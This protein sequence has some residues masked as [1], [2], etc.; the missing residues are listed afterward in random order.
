MTSGKNN[1]Y[2]LTHNARYMPN[3]DGVGSVV[4]DISGLKFTVFI[5]VHD[6]VIADIN[7]IVFDSEAAIAS[8]ELT[9]KYLKGKTIRDALHIMERQ[10]IDK[11]ASFADFGETDP[12]LGFAALKEAIA[13]YL[14]KRG[15]KI[16]DYRR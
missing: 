9:A 1:K 6:E 15:R 2:V 16:E 10:G 8:G 5:R 14:Q 13:S 7:F 11:D 3:A 4:D 12:H